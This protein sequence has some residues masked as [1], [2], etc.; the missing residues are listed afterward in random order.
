MD[1]EDSKLDV[2]DIVILCYGGTIQDILGKPSTKGTVISILDYDDMKSKM[3]GSEINRLTG[4]AI[5]DFP[6]RL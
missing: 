3:T 1:S 6:V 5:H 2:S 4:K